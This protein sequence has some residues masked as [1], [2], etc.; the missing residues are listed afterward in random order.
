[1]L[2][3]SADFTVYCTFHYLA[4][5]EELR[6]RVELRPLRRP[7]EDGR[8]VDDDGGAPE[9]AP[10]PVV[11]GAHVAAA[12]G[13]LGVGDGEA[14]VLGV[15]LGVGAD[16]GPEDVRLRVAARH[17]RHRHVFAERHGV[18]LLGPGQL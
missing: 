3:H 15:H 14:A 18:P 8:R 1:M 9:E 11:D 16:L 2:S 5:Q 10:R 7:R 13:L 6:A 12:V 4:V 17:A